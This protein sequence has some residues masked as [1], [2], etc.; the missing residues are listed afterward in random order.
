MNAVKNLRPP[1]AYYG[2]KFGTI[3][4]QI[5][6]F[7]ND[8]PHKIYMELFG[9]M[10]GV[11][12]LKKPSLIEVYNDLDS[13]IVNLFKD[14]RKC[15][16]LER[17]LKLTPFSREEYNLSHQ[18][19]K[20]TDIEDVELA[21]ATIV[22]LSFSIQPSLRHN[23]FKNGGKKYET[24]IARQFRRR[25]DNLSSLTERFSNVIIENCP[26]E[27]LLV[28]FDDPDTL[29]YL[30]PPYIRS[31]RNKSSKNQLTKNDYAFEMDDDYHKVLLLVAKGVKSKVI[32]SGYDHPLYNDL[33][34]DWHRTE[35][36]V[37]SAIAG[38]QMNAGDVN[39]KRMEVLWSNFRL[40]PQIKMD[41]R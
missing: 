6:D 1:S 28:I 23:G 30:D 17:R 38:S 12:L 3:G 19:L 13:R 34:S 5:A 41:F 21:R 4:G 25:I 26:A 24:S 14:K 35:I 39:M 9:G 16:E 31:T 2:G 20:Q 36:E 22:A 37:T 32:I 11:L 15:K 40:N 27:K 29:V 18:L 8:V 10:A 33:L 7:I